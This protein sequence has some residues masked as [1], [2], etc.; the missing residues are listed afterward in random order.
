MEQRE[1]VYALFKAG[2]TG[3]AIAK[4][5]AIGFPRDEPP[6]APIKVTAQAVNSLYR[7]QIRENEALH[8]IDL[9]KIPTDAQMAT[10]RGKLA[11]VANRE[12][13]RLADRQRLG[14]L[15]P[16]QL[17]KLARAVTKIED[18]EAAAIKRET[19]GRPGVKR[20]SV[21]NAPDDQVA[22]DAP[23]FAESL[24]RPVP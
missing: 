15:D 14:K 23:S 24:I 13:D 22:D 1:K 2:H 17:A 16:D 9:A 10:L 18:M 5:L 21:G 12:I 8:A 3:T 20:K 4:M 7:S 19:A 6:L 11:K